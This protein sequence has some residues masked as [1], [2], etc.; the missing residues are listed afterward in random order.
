MN[1]TQK[2][3]IEQEA[4][5]SSSDP[6]DGPS[7]E[8]LSTAVWVTQTNQVSARAASSATVTFLVCT[9]I[10]TRDLPIT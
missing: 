4:Q 8:I 1:D 10:V 9:R 3:S 6:R 2:T 5:L 7:V